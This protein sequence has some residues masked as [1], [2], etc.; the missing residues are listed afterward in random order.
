[1]DIDQKTQGAAQ[2]ACLQ[3]AGSNAIGTV[4][5]AKP[6]S[7]EVDWAK[8]SSETIARYPNILAALAE[9][10]RRCDERKRKA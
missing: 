10:E 4:L 7:G 5:R 6:A 3:I 2:E 1:M 9:A 8:L